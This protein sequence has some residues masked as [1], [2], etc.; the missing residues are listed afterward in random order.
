VGRVPDPLDFDR[1]GFIGGDFSLASNADGFQTPS[2]ELVT[3]A[4]GA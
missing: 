1:F 2:F 4:S 3:Q